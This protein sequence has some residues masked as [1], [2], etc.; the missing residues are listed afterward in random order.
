MVFKNV[1]VLVLWTKVASALE[2]LTNVI[3]PYLKGPMGHKCLC[4][5]TSDIPDLIRTASESGNMIAFTK[6]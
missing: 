1:C 4:V 6:K 3:G 5:F 2:G